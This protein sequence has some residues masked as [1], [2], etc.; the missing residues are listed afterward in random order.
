[1]CGSE[2]W[3][4]RRSGHIADTARGRLTFFLRSREGVVVPLKVVTM[5]EFRLKLLLE[6]PGREGP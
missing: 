3:P 2:T 1:V 4:T 6:A 5:A